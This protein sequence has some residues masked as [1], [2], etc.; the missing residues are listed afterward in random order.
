MKKPLVLIFCLLGALSLF[1]QTGREIAQMVEDQSQVDTLQGRMEMRLINSAGEVSTRVLDQFGKTENGLT[2]A[3][4]IFQSPANVR[5]TRFL[6]IENEGREEDRWIYL[7]NLR[8]TR[9]IA[10]GEGSE[11]FM[12]S[13]FTY[14]D[15]SGRDID[16]GEYTLLREEE[17]GGEKVWVL[18]MKAKDQE[19]TQY[20][21]VI[22]WISQEKKVALKLEMFDKQGE[23]LKTLE[24]SNITKVQGFWT[25][26]LLKMTN[27]QTGNATELEIKRLV[28]NQDVPNIFT[29]SFLETGRM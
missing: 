1:G 26:I 18:E 20:S 19:S 22:S 9:R 12:G 14:D 2:K 5:G 11:S 21:K 29:T 27:V 13:E 28:Y 6:T 4:V 8:R 17:L 7:P 16:E 3:M 24:A 15:I 25:P 23:L 10:G